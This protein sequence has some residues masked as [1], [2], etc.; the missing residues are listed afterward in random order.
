MHVERTN[1]GLMVYDDNNS[2]YMPISVDSDIVGY[3]L[4]GNILVITYP[5]KNEV[6]N[7]ENNTRI[8]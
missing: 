4:S 8:R 3:N 7:V 6:Y 1:N 2:P 5:S